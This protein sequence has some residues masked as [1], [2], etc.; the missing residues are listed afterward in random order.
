[1]IDLSHLNF[2]PLIISISFFSI[3]FSVSPDIDSF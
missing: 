2:L 1:M 3:L